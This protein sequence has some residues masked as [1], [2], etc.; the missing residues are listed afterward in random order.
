MFDHSNY[1]ESMNN[2]MIEYPRNY[3]NTNV[4]SLNNS[5]ITKNDKELTLKPK[6]QDAQKQEK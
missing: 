3:T 5:L 2:T 6:L 4:H 1:K